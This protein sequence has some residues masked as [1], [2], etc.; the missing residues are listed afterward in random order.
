MVNSFK[1]V[2]INEV[3]IKFIK[4][5]EN[6]NPEQKARDNIDALLKEAGW[7]VQSNK[8]ID[9]NKGDGL[10]G[11]DARAFSKTDF[12]REWSGCT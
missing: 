12:R 3:P 11:S 4:M 9:F 6:Q 1:N 8:Q 2:K 5:S 10:C 7:V